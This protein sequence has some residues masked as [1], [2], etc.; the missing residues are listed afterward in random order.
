[1]T[2]GDWVSVGMVFLGYLVVGVIAFFAL[3]Q[4]V[5]VLERLSEQRMAAFEQLLSRLE[6]KI[7]RMME[8][9]QETLQREIEVLRGN[10]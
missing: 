10:G 9:R 1:M 3:R 7:D 6:A 2:A 5:A 4:Q 8:M